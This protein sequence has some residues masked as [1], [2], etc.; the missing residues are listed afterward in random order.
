[1]GQTYPTN[2]PRAFAPGNRPLHP[3]ETMPGYQPWEAPT[4]DA[5]PGAA[6]DNGLVPANDN[7]KKSRADILRKLAWLKKKRGRWVANPY[8]IIA[9]LLL[10]IVQNQQMMKVNPGGMWVKIHECPHFYGGDGGSYGYYAGDKQWSFA[11]DPKPTVPSIDPL[12]YLESGLPG[13]QTPPDPWYSVYWINTATS[14][15]HSRYTRQETYWRTAL[16]PRYQSQPYVYPYHPF[17]TAWP[18][19]L[20]EAFPKPNEVRPLPSRTPSKGWPRIEPLVPGMPGYEGGYAPSPL[21]VAVQWPAAVW[22]AGKDPSVPA[23]PITQP[24]QFTA[25]KP[26]GPRVKE[27]KVTTGVNASVLGHVLGNVTEFVDIENALWNALPKAYRSRLPKGYGAPKSGVPGWSY[28]GATGFA[29]NGLDAR[30]AYIKGRDLYRHWD[31]VDIAAAF[32]NL[33]RNEVGDRMTASMNRRMVRAWKRNPYAVKGPFSP[34][35]GPAL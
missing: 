23:K 19:A 26:S 30:V 12:C 11:S 13:L 17:V 1:M 14:Q 5:P 2:G 6:N 15:A 35:T 9:D 10:Q 27:K 22:T 16:R 32:K 3:G 18:V 7:F 25:R 28:K 20:P 24:W 8:G 21:P 34:Q 4:F 31:K 33:V 29:P